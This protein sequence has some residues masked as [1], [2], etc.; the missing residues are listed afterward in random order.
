L[1]RD[2]L[3]LV[4]GRGEQR[5]YYA[6]C[7]GTFTYPPTYGAK[8][9]KVQNL[10]KIR[11]RIHAYCGPAERLTFEK[12]TQHLVQWKAFK[13]VRS[14]VDTELFVVW[15]PRRFAIEHNLSIVTMGRLKKQKEWKKNVV[16]RR[17]WR[18]ERRSSS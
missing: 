15:V 17:R 9:R 1:R 12:Q 8:M 6:L 2:D 4:F 11:H 5:V 16:L 13:T 3:A 7:A 18:R 10:R 14:R